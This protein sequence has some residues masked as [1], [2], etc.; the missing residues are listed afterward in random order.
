MAVKKLIEVALP[1]EAINAASARE[2]SIRHGHPSTLHLWWA[3]RPL[4]TARA[5]IWASLV[6]DPSSHPEKFPTTEEQDKERRR[7]FGILEELVVWENSNDRRVIES[8]KSEIESSMGQDQ[9]CFL[10]PFAGGGAI[11][12]EAQRLGLEAHA[13]DLN[14]VA[15]TINKAMIEIPPLFQGYSPIR[16]MSD[17][18]RKLG[19]WSGASGIASDVEYYGALLK[20]R[21]FERLQRYYPLIDSNSA[22]TPSDTPA[23]SW[24]WAR[25]I[26]CSNPACECELPLIK[27]YAISKKQKKYVH[28]TYDGGRVSFAV[29]DTPS[30]LGKGTVSRKGI[31]CPNCGAPISFEEARRQGNN[32]EIKYRMMA[33]V[34]EGNRKK[35]YL[36]PTESQASAAES[37][38][39]PETSL[40]DLAIYPGYINPPAY[41]MTTID[42]LF[43]DRQLMM[44]EA[45]CEELGI[46]RD[47][48]RDDAMKSGVFDSEGAGLD[49]GGSSARAYSEAITVYLA[50]AIDKLADR[51]SSL[52]GWDSSRDGMS[53]T[54]SMTGMSMAWDFAE[55]NPFSNSTGCFDNMLDWVIRC[56][57]NYQTPDRGFVKQ[58]DAQ[59]TP[60]LENLIVS[61]DPPYYSNVPYAD[62][63]DFFYV[64]LRRNLRSIYPNLYRTMLTPKNEELVADPY[65]ENRGKE[66]AREFFE[67]GMFETFKQLAPCVRDDVPVSIYYAFKQ[68]ETETVND[69]E[70]TASTGWETMLA[71]IIKSGFT[72]T[73][74]WPMRTEMANRTIA[75]AQNALSSSIVLVC[76]KRPADAPMA[77][78]REFVNTLKR[79]LKPALDKLQTSNIAPVDMA[80]SAIGPGIGVYS[81][82]SKVLEAD[83]SEM[84][85]RAALQIINQELDLYFSDQDSD[86]DRDSRFCVD[87][88][89]QSAF[90]EIKFGEADVLAR[91]KNTSID[92]LTSKGALFASKGIVRL[93]GRDELKNAND[94]SFTWLFTQQLTH[95]METGG[96]E[97]CAQMLKDVFDS[98]AE[99]AKALAYRLFTIADKKGWNAEAFAYNSL[100]VA[101]PEIQSRAAQLQAEKPV[102]YTLFDD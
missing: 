45:F 27:S 30:K 82:F 97:A 78:R 48:I 52:C 95:A 24:L 54:F 42:S 43:T 28:L 55:A 69:V 70:S 20:S 61:T 4:A 90:N 71:A 21:V 33:V 66:G 64:W 10:D 29:E 91:A 3:R 31:V 18:E 83:G 2:K 63:A 13:H 81:R 76:R 22:G 41:G 79:E 58:R 38:V 72:I 94:W 25:V 19:A 96:V 88:Y 51:S 34:A 56:I 98:R 60:G 9:M 23:V 32:G 11:P 47:V 7:L 87:L 57:K 53:H 92:G 75:F 67:T 80:Q 102:Q 39:R 89:T 85:V 46:L 5:V 17:A 73:G 49:A 26:R 1:L 68:S 99:N 35:V 100:V 93:L 36:S 12:L 62:F 101:W 74:T 40:G 37:A 59:S 44:L 50:F 15:V 16:P 86:L 8:A 65:R 84:T 6:D 77:T 14:P